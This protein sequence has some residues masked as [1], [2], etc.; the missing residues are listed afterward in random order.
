MWSN[1]DL[2]ELIGL[3]HPIIQAPMASATGPALVAAVSETGALGSYGAAS[4]SPEK[5]REIILEIQRLTKR[6]FNINLFYAGT[7]KFDTNARP[8]ADLRSVVQSFH[9]ELSLGEM[10]EPA[11]MFGPAERQL[12]VLIEHKVP[13]ISFH[14]G[15]DADTVERAKQDGAKVLCSATTVKEAKILEAAGVDAVIAQGAEAGGHRGTFDGRWQDALIGTLALVPQIADAV[16]IPVIAAGGIMDARGLVASLALGA[17][18]V[19][20]GTAFL[21]SVEA[22]VNDAW[23]TKLLESDAVNTKVT[24]AI[25]G[26]PARGIRNRYM[27]SIENGCEQLLPYPLQYSLSRTLRKHAGENDDV[28]FMAMWAGQGVALAETQ[29]AAKFIEKL[30]SESNSLVKQ[31]SK[32]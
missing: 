4:T 28:D 1:V 24:K 26:K 15:V 32:T 27:E 22:P 17:S 11:P 21:T 3:E 31:L 5:L 7:E 29:E 13:V 8:A 20:M 10:P 23:R 18:G 9:D 30:V 12:D 14:F 19:Q 16:N 2:L 25:S 6:P